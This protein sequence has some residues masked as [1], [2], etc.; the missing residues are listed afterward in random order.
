MFVMFVPQLET[1]PFWPF[2][3]VPPV[4]P[5]TFVQYSGVMPHWP[6]IS[7]QELRGHRLRAASAV[8]LVGIVVQGTVGPRC[9]LETGTG[10]GGSPLLKQMWLSVWRLS[11][12][13]QPQVFLSLKSLM[14]DALSPLAAAMEEHVSCEFTW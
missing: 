6:Q 10:I 7:Q 2:G 11:H 1:H 3:A 13:N 12:P 4:G 5:V 14:S 9:A 8:P